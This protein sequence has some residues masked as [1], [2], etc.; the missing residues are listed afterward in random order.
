MN[1][2]WKNLLNDHSSMDDEFIK[3]F[4]KLN[5]L[6]DKDLVLTD[7][8][9]N[10]FLIKRTPHYIIDGFYYYKL[11][12]EHWIVEYIGNKEITCGDMMIRNVLT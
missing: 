6:F 5:Y 1:H 7:I 4:L 12:N 9:K 11:V 3:M 2:N 10:C 8:C